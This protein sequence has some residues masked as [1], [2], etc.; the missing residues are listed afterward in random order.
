M[1]RRTGSKFNRDPFLFLGPCMV[2]AEVLANRDFHFVALLDDLKTAVV[3][4]GLV[5]R[6][7]NRQVPDILDVSVSRSV[8]VCRKT[9]FG[10]NVKG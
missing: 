8:N 10:R 5:H 4:I 7:E 3:H 2:D 9:A 1:Q 6:K